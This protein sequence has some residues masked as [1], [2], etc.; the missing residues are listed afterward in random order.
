MTLDISKTPVTPNGFAPERVAVS[1]MVSVGAT[2]TTT[3]LRVNNFQ[4]QAIDVQE[5]GGESISNVFINV[6]GV[7]GA[8]SLTSSFSVDSASLY[9]IA[10]SFKSGPLATSRLEWT[11]DNKTGT[12]YT[13]SGSGPIPSYLN[14][15]IKEMTVVDK[16]QRNFPLSSKENALAQKYGL[17]N[18]DQ[19]NLPI[20]KSPVAEPTLEDKEIVEKSGVAGTFNITKTGRTG[21]ALVAS[22]SSLARRSLVA[23]VTGVEVQ[24]NPNLSQNVYLEFTRGGSASFYDLNLQALP[25]RSQRRSIDLFI[26]FIDQMDVQLWSPSTINNVSVKLNYVLVERTVVEKALYDLTDEAENQSLFN[27]VKDR[28][29][30]GVS[31]QGVTS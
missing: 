28:L 10:D 1:D 14:Y 27:E 9:D 30:A 2:S 15:I 25:G 31:L 21:G 19:K 23:Y 7:N 11:I 18:L 26:P 4:N 20:V 5:I 6:T 17:T 13:V 12:D 24:G 29:A 16:M 8:E 3:V 22:E